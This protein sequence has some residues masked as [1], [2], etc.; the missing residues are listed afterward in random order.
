MDRELVLHKH[1]GNRRPETNL[2]LSNSAPPTVGP[3]TRGWRHNMLRAPC[4]CRAFPSGGRASLGFA[5]ER[6][7]S[8]AS[9]RRCCHAVMGKTALAIGPLTTD[10]S[11]FVRSPTLAFANTRLGAYIENYDYDPGERPQAQSP[12]GIDRD[13]R[14]HTQTLGARGRSIFP[15]QGK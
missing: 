15:P 4:D 11:L 1:G 10:V 3:L 7:R 6:A 5:W 2:S 12:S 13:S 8:H 14:R 9:Q